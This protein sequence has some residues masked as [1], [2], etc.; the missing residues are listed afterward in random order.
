MQVDFHGRFVP[1]LCG[2]GWTSGLLAGRLKIES[3]GLYDG[4]SAIA[5]KA[6]GHVSKCAPRRRRRPGW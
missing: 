3:P 4:P 1:T 6:V 2:R 5:D